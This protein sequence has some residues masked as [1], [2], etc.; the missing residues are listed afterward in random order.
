M[1]RFIASSF[2][3]GIEVVWMASMSGVSIC[4]SMM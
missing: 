3:A 4:T 1:E 2:E